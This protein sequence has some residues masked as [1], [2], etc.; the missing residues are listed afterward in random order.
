MRGLAA[1]AAAL[2]SA[3]GSIP[4]DIEDTSDRVQQTQI[5]RVGVIAG[6]ANERRLEAF[7][8]RASEA[9]SA[10]AAIETGSTEPLLKK[11]QRGALDIVV[12]PM[13]GDS[14]WA[15]QV[16]FMPL[17]AGEPA[18]PDRL[19]YLAMAR[20]GENEWIALLHRQASAVAER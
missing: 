6:P 18:P 2:L 12:G 9:T 20:N 11:L 13:A 15:T 4:A 10:R 7:L 5:Y 19:Q 14:G 8:D 1:V 17:Q 3:C 16:H